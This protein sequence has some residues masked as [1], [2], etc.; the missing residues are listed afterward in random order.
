MNEE[1]TDYPK[2]GERIWFDDEKR[3][4]KVR[5]GNER[6]TICTKP[7][8]PKKT[9]IYSIIDWVERKRSTE[10]LIFCMGFETDEECEEALQRLI[11]GKSELSKRNQIDLFVKRRE[12]AK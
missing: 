11:E 8:N 1:L 2:K 12:A 6:Y 10:N 3:P 5:A 9:V 4:Y 7:F